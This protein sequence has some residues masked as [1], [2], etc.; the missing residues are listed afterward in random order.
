MLYTG[1]KGN[2]SP[3]HGTIKKHFLNGKNIDEAFMQLKFPAIKPTNNINSKNFDY[4]AIQIGNSA[5]IMSKNDYF[6]GC[7]INNL[8]E[9]EFNYP[10][11]SCLFAHDSFLYFLPEF[12][13]AVD[14]DTKKE[15]TFF[16]EEIQSMAYNLHMFCTGHYLKMFE[17]LYKYNN[18][19]GEE[20]ID[21]GCGT[22][23]L[24][25]SIIRLYNDTKNQAPNLCLYD[26]SNSMLAMAFNQ[27]MHFHQLNLI[28]SQY[29]SKIRLI[30]GEA[31]EISKKIKN[32]SADTVVCSYC[33][34]WFGPNK[35]KIV[36]E[37][38]KILKFG[39]YFISLEEYPLVVTECISHHGIPCLLNN[40]KKDVKNVARPIEI[41]KLYKMFQSF[42]FKLVKSENLDI[43]NEHKIYGA[44]FLK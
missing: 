44:V 3:L 40:L 30:K 6:N 26:H 7:L 18:Y 17:M 42:G 34:H 1:T 35:E 24:G 16:L 31:Q 36:G 9:K 43:D 4:I 38:Y 23:E 15:N 22:G 13:N 12:E 25:A 29:K 33:F 37:I 2:I 14:L 39:G 20:I 27:G 8:E 5:K 11:N 32:N 19:L 41:K 21:I 28:N 10:V